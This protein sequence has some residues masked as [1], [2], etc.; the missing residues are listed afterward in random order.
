LEDTSHSDLSLINETNKNME[1]FFI[2]NWGELLIGILAFAKVVVNI[3]PTETD[4]KIFGWLDSL[5]NMIIS[6]RKKSKE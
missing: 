6:D 2:Q 5:I 4:N 1:S 3:T